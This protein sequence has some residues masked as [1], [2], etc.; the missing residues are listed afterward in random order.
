MTDV[1]R[2]QANGIELACRIDGPGDPA[3]PWLV[4]AHA[5]A[6]DHRMWAEQAAEFATT[7]NVLRYDLRGHGAS[8][9]PVGEY[10]L[11]LLADDLR[12]LLDAL[13]IRRCHFVGL[14]LGGMIGQ[15]AALR[16]PLRFA[17]LTLADTSSRYPAEMKSTWEQRIAA[18][19]TPDGM[20]PIMAGT[21]E[22]WF[23]PAYR[24]RGTQ[25][26][27]D[28]GRQ[29]LATPVNGYIGCIQA[30]AKLNLTLRL[31]NIDCP[32]LV[33]VGAEDR[34]TPQ[35]MAEEIVRAIP[36]AR[37]Q[38]IAQAAHLSNVEQPAA[39]NA[40]LRAHLEHSVQ[41]SD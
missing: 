7:F 35:S 21:L 28:M 13:A 17:S 32:V 4:L 26:M 6:S 33:I 16:F 37:L 9:A 41:H 11:E 12:A 10:T 23:T 5:L 3:R 24:A 30:I 25:R 8:S 40:A 38:V 29:I 18:V 2:V 27:L 14:S 20:K 15:M 36:G 19:K 1:R 22:R 34:G 39:F 31:Q